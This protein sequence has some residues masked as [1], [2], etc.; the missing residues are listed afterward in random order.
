MRAL[1]LLFS[2]ALFCYG[3]N[4]FL[5]NT[6]V[7]LN[8]DG[9]NDNIVA[10]KSPVRGTEVIAKSYKNDWKSASSDDWTK[11]FPISTLE[12]AETYSLRLNISKNDMNRILDREN[13]LSGMAYEEIINYLNGKQ[14]IFALIS[15][16]FRRL[17]GF[18]ENVEYG[19]LIVNKLET[20]V[21]LEVSSTPFTTDS[22]NNSN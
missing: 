5:W 16:F 18:G 12:Y 7:T 21:D 6:K 4:A 19:K 8:F 11:N 20:S 2:L 3:V 14:T 13:D 15:S 9:K 17:L 1:S 10:L 22:G